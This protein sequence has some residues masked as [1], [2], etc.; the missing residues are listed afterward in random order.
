MLDT[1]TQTC[2]LKDSSLLRQLRTGNCVTVSGA[3]DI[4]QMQFRLLNLAESVVLV[5][6]IIRYLTTG[7]E[8]TRQTF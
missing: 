1:Q 6:V 2:P 8:I 7:S 3:L 5:K 4:S